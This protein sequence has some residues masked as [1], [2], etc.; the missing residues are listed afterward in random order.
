MVRRF[1]TAKRLMLYAN[2]KIKENQLCKM[3]GQKE[4]P[5]NFIGVY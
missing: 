3:N 5:M 2:I 1:W 4:T